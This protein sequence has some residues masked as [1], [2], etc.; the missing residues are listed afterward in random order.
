MPTKKA[1]NSVRV[2]GLL[3][4]MNRQAS[5]PPLSFLFD[6]SAARLWGLRMTPLSARAGANTPDNTPDVSSLFGGASGA[7]KLSICRTKVDMSCT[8]AGMQDLQALAG[9]I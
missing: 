1:Q 2:V 6:H 7:N 8:D 3:A 5:N 9:S 4:I